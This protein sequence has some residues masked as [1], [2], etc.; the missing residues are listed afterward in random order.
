[1]SECGQ[2]AGKRKLTGLKETG[3]FE[4]RELNKHI[5]YLL[6]SYLSDGTIGETKKGW[7]YFNLEVID[8]DFA[9][10]VQE[11]INNLTGQ[12]LDRLYVREAGVSVKREYFKAY[13]GNQELCHWMRTVTR[14][15]QQIPQVIV[16]AAPTL[17]RWFIAGLMDGDGWICAYKDK[18]GWILGYA[19]TDPW[20]FDMAEML[21]ALS[22]TVHGPRRQ[23]NG[24]VKPLYAMNINKNTFI[25]AGCF[26]TISRKQERLAEY[27]RYMAG[28]T[29]SS[30]ETKREPSTK[31]DEVI[32]RP[33]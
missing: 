5:A 21:R 3:H 22:V 14:N 27:R 11:A 26:F 28:S 31:V 19:G 1:M 7:L 32:V 8:E 30:S 16:D 33:S 29:Q 2:L 23:K 18:P 17:Q 24:G 9:T 12:L 4:F 15:R 6:G 10:N 20:V 13:S 25:E